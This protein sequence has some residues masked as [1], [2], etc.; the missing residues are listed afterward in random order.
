MADYKP[1]I[2]ADVQRAVTAV[3]N[4]IASLGRDAPLASDIIHMNYSQATVDEFLRNSQA[5]VDS[6]R[7]A[8]ERA[9]SWLADTGDRISRNLDEARRVEAA[10]RD[11]SCQRR[12]AEAHINSTEESI[13]TSESSVQHAQ[14]SLASARSALADARD[15]ME[16]AE[17]R[18]RAIHI[19]SMV[20]MLFVPILAFGVAAINMKAMSDNLDEHCN[21]VRSLEG[22]LAAST[23]ELDAR[24][25]TLAQQQAERGR[26]ASSV[27][28]LQT[29]A[30]ELAV[31]GRA[32][33]E[34]RAS[35]AEL[36]RRIN[37]CLYAVNAALGCSTAIT[38]MCSMRNVVTGIR[39]VV[40]GLGRDEMFVGPLALL[41]EAAFGA[42]DRRVATIRRSQ[43]T[44]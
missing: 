14:A 5:V 2:V 40:S 25:D 41:D 21:A 4:I 12:D 18:H 37:D 23:A 39:G 6:I 27:A 34:A 20:A 31:E 28:G 30:D 10:A 24:R 22:Q 29:R 43:L 1:L 35:L 26:L 3:N 42:L 16:E 11:T 15:S 7:S 38:T 36:S 13:R 8:S 33:D 44:V 9:S 32:F 17:N 19:G